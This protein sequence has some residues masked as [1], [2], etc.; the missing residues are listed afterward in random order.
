MMT[1][2]AHARLQD[3]LAATKILMK[4]DLLALVPDSSAGIRG[5]L[6]QRVHGRRRPQL[7]QVRCPP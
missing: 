5:R 3:V 1:A 6:Y 4:E 7:M 2:T